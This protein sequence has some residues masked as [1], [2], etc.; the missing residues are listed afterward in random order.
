MEELLAQG[1]SLKHRGLRKPG[2]PHGNQEILKTQGMG[3]GLLRLPFLWP[4][5]CRITAAVS[6]L[7]AEHSGMHGLFCHIPY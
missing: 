2:S 7:P 3:H 5:L 4:G 6:H 1:W